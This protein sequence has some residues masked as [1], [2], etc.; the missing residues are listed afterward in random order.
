[1]PSGGLLSGYLYKRGGGSR[2]FGSTDWKKRFF[3]LDTEGVV[4]YYKLQPTSSESPQGQFQLMGADVVAT[5]TK[6][7]EVRGATT[8]D[9]PNRSQK[10]QKSGA[11]VY[12][13][14]ADTTEVRDTWVA[15][16]TAASS[17]RSH[18]T[19]FSWTNKR[20]GAT[21][22]HPSRGRADTLTKH[23]APP[24]SPDGLPPVPPLDDSERPAVS[25]AVVY[26][27]EGSPVID[28]LA[29]VAARL[30]AYAHVSA[31]PSAPF[32]SAA[33]SEQAGVAKQ[34]EASIMHLERAADGA[35]VASLEGL[36]ARLER[37]TGCS[38]G[39]VSA[40]GGGD[41]DKDM[42]AMVRRLETLVARIETGVLNM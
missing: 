21:D 15:A 27:P 1:M 23:G 33:G 6:G 39:A 12:I 31:P 36:T 16:L 17:S 38:G 9:L 29:A 35:C 14:E 2:M 7:F 25:S 10:S 30:G 28:G 5:G 22:A 42:A 19:S 37:C 34:L 40:N 11:R 8:D 32:A 4:R 3:V 26:V 18:G 20:E 41:G 24:A 13:M